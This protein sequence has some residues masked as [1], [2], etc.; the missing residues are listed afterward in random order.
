MPAGTSGDDL[1]F[2]STG[3]ESFDGGAGVDTVSYASSGAV[4]VDLSAGEST[5]ILKVMPFGDSI[6]YGVISSNQVKNENSGGYRVPLW[7]DLQASGLAIDYVGAIKSGPATFPDRDNEG[8]RGQTIEYLNSV[9]AGLL[10]TYKPDVVMLMIG[11]NDAA[12][13]SAA[14]MISELRDLI[15]SIGTASPSTTIF[16][17]GIPPIYNSAQN[18]IAQQYDA[19][20]PG[21]IDELNDTYKVVFVDTGNVTLSDITPPP[22]DWGVHPT[23]AGYEKLATDWFNAIMASDVFEDERD[24]LISIENVTGSAYTDKLAGD[25]GSNVLS[26]L[27]GDDQLFGGGGG[28]T[29]DGG[30]GADRM[31]GG[32][33]D[34]TYIVDS[35]SDVVIEK[36]G[37]GTDTIRTTKTTYS[38]ANLPYVENLTYNGTSAAKL[39]GNA[40]D[41]RIEGGPGADTID[42]KEGADTML[43][44][45]GSDTYIVDNSGDVVTESGAGNDTVKASVSFV[46]GPNIE[47]LTL[48]GIASIDGTGNEFG[49][50]VTGNAGTNNLYGLGGNDTLIG[51][52]GDDYLYGGDGT[53]VLR[54]GAGADV[55]TGGLG[56]DKF[57]W[58]AV[59]DAG[60][61]ATRD[62]VLDFTH[63]S[64][65]VDL[66]TI[67]AKSG[68]G[69]N[70][71][72]TFIGTADFSGAAGQLRSELIHSSGGDYTLVQAD[73]N[74]DGIADFE[75]ALVGY[76]ATVQSNDFVL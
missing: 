37:E 4:N 14:T 41:N 36:A 34:D 25:D 43:G 31:T 22:A 64:D 39:T 67:D 19:M 59:V 24:T 35:S 3:N 75:I 47:K 71:S 26:G 55:L 76:T 17:A 32:T 15:I 74:G 51:G 18:A 57:D 45:A 38:L 49:N 62:Q 42:G 40:A 33:G 61:G 46:L 68:S 58:D 7:N 28:D 48:T 65:K 2:A 69:S 73:V 50:T 21:L 23:V 1:F 27:A 11:T 54:G 60:L 8:L 20:M 72:F 70:D 29:L 6:T 5:P 13:D 16:V 63:G 53:D 12:D 10:A 66:S 56:S 9:D 30:A 52:G 44:G